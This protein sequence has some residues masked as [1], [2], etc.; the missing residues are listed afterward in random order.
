MTLL[1]A[2]FLNIVDSSHHF[3]QFIGIALGIDLFLSPFFSFLTAAPL[4]HRLLRAFVSVASHHTHPK[5]PWAPL[6]RPTTTP[7]CP[8]HIDTAI[9]TSATSLCEHGHQSSALT[10]GTYHDEVLSIAR[11]LHRHRRFPR[12]CIRSL[13]H[14]LTVCHLP[15]RLL[16][17]H[18]FVR[19]PVRTDQT[20]LVPR[21][22]LPH[23]LFAYRVR[24][25]VPNCL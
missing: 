17:H 13:P 8:L 7:V 9:N 22:G 20:H 10:T 19:P 1:F 18:P 3:D 25:E 21:H 5:R 4:P 23:A 11:P 2:A 15:M 6:A 14:R 16:P 12:R 24:L